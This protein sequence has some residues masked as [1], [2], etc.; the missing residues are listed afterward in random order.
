MQDPSAVLRTRTDTDNPLLLKSRYKYSEATYSEA[1]HR[2][3]TL[4]RS[5]VPRSHLQAT[6]SEAVHSEA[7]YSEAVHSEAVFQRLRE[8]LTINLTRK[9]GLSYPY[10]GITGLEFK[11]EFMIWTT[12]TETGTP[13]RRNTYPRTRT[14][15]LK[16][17]TH[18]R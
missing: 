7:T 12:S 14:T 17:P 4:Q 10:S 18:T 3:A 15:Y 13:Y 5:R 6:Y 16:M 9:F 1:V 2:E 11:L 8:K